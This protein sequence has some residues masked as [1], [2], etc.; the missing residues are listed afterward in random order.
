MSRRHF[1]ASRQR[2]FSCPV[3]IQTMSTCSH[4]WPD[5]HSVSLGGTQSLRS[6]AST[7][8]STTA[9]SQYMQQPSVALPDN[10]LPVNEHPPPPPPPTPPQF[11][12]RV[13]HDIMPKWSYLYYDYDCN[14]VLRQSMME[15]WSNGMVNFFNE[16]GMHSG[17]H[18]FWRGELPHSVYCA[19]P[20]GTP[21][22]SRKSSSVL[23][24]KE[25]PHDASII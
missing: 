20:P 2:V 11:A 25:S 3:G 17:P 9:N 7:P 10:E 22:A 1:A 18:G 16:D 15:L 14:E 24:V 12:S 5:T 6:L 4:S 21:L 13:R 8:M 19:S 23:V